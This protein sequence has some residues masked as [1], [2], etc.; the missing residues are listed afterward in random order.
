MPA[1][2]ED[3]AR[4]V[5]HRAAALD[6]NLLSRKSRIALVESVEQAVPTL[7]AERIAEL[8]PRSTLGRAMVAAV[9]DRNGAPQAAVAVRAASG[10]TRPEEIDLL[11]ARTIR[12]I[13][14]DAAVA[15]RCVEALPLL[16][17]AV[18][19]GLGDSSLALK[20]AGCLND[21][22]DGRRALAVLVPMYE[23]NPG[24]RWVR[25]F[26]AEAEVRLGHF[27]E[28]ERIARALAA[29][30]PDFYDVWR[31]GGRLYVLLDRPRDAARCYRRALYLRPGNTWLLR[32]IR[33]LERAARSAEATR[34]TPLPAPSTPDGAE[35]QA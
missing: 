5:R 21:A 9:L 34:V 30:D 14:L 12:Q 29:S 20:Y 4:S 2:A 7:G 3:F 10:P 18:E 6:A 8:A 22:G 16:D 35:P 15:D 17:A 32:D 33:K 13:G 19:R 24:S 27:E 31:F 28:A 26:L 23:E 25:L 11:P 1:R